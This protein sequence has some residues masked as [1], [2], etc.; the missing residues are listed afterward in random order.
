MNM[1][2]SIA[3]TALAVTAVLG[4]TVCLQ[5]VWAAT[6]QNTVVN[7]IQVRG[8]N[9]VTRGAVLLALP[10]KPGDA[11]TQENVARSMKQLYATGDFDEVKLSQDGGTLY[12]DVTERPTIAGVQF[13]GNSNISDD[14]LRPVIEQQ[15]LKEGEPL[16]TRDLS[17]VQKSLEDFYH[18]AGMY[19]AQVKPV[20]TVLPRNRVNVKLE[21]S[22]GISAEIQQ[23]NIVGNKAFDDSTLLAQMQLR[24]D[25]PWWNFMSN[26]K[27]DVQKFHADLDALRSYY[28][29]HGYLKFKIE[30]T[31][32]EMTPDKKGLYLTIVINEGEQYRVGKSTVQGN[33]LTYGEGLTSL[34]SLKEGNVY[35]QNEVTDNEKILKDYLG[36]YGYAYSEVKAVPT[37]DDKEHKVDLAFNVEPGSRVYVAQIQISGNDTT[38]DTVIRREMRQMDGTWLSNEAL[39]TSKTRLNR[40]GYFESVDIDMQRSGTTADVVTLDTKVKEQPTGAIQGAIGFG[41][42]SGLL[43]SASVSQS[44]LFGWGTKGVIS[45]YK[46]DYRK[47]MELA[48]TDPYF[49]V[50]NISL[51]GRVYLDRYYGDDDDVVDY[52]NRTIGMEINSGYPLAENWRV[53]YAAGYEN[54]R[55]TNTGRRFQQAD[56][57]WKKY[58][59]NP[60][61]RTATFNNYNLTFSL[62]H[63]ALDRAVFPTDGNKQVLTAMATAPNSDNQYYKFTAETYHFYPF[64]IDHLWVFSV[65]ARAGFADG[66]GDDERLPFFKNFYL[67]S[68]SWL[69]GFDHNSIGPKAIYYRKLDGETSQTYDKAHA[70]ESSTSVGGNAFWAASAEMFVPTPLVP[71]AYKA[72]VRTSF[73]YDVGALWDTH[74]DD[75]YYNSNKAGDYRA[76]VGVAFTWVSPIGPLSFSLSKA[77]K[78]MDGD[79]TQFFTFDIGGTF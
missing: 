73:F 75:Y 42:D 44:N 40:T 66:Y 32:V 58:S 6:A 67:G 49:T 68:S 53:D 24:D 60:D 31:A 64:D 74:G 41:T 48:Y 26:Q 69:R 17:Q 1:K 15:G 37:F 34:L 3:K 57:F 13:S 12:V 28:L 16:N 5:N 45:A 33:T 71:E 19:Q 43:L 22:E 18:G 30:N 11:V 25:V 54:S 47:H 50:D 23:I 78:K 46:N 9:R 59:S 76:S 79:D 39:E 72:S 36:K 56:L 20:V 14:N 52:D 4:V 8:L 55:I 65:R 7:N 61:N 38:D 77:V 10:I 35:S 62:T 63:N 70:Y 51:G 27:Y 21:F 29:N 2:N